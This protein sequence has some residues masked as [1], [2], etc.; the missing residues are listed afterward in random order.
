MIIECPNLNPRRI[1][2]YEE[3][4]RKLPYRPIVALRFQKPELTNRNV[5]IRFLYL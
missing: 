2:Y 3:I 5:L 4:T 1:G